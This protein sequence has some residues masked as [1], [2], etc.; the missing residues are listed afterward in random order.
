MRLLAGEAVTV[1]ST[2]ARGASNVKAKH[3]LDWTLRYPSWRQGFVQAYGKPSASTA[4]EIATP[5]RT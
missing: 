2:E 4:T 5:A 1:M 3:E